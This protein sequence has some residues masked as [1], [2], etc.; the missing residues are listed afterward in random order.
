MK[1]PVF[2]EN[3]YQKFSRD[4]AIDLGTA[5][6]RVYVKNHGI[7]VSEPSVV[8]INQKTGRVVA[9]GT[10]AKQ[11]LG[12]T[13]LHISAERPLVEG[14]ISNFEVAEEMVRYFL[15]KAESILPRMYAR[16]RIL[17]SVPS[18]ITNVERRAV[19]DAVRNA[20]TREVHVIE[21]PVAAA[22][23]ISLPINEPVGSMIV[24]VGGG[25][26]DVAVL[27]LSG[28][29]RSKNLR[30]A[31][32]RLNSDIVNYVKDEFKIFLGDR[33]AEE[34]KIAIGSVQEEDGL[35]E[36]AVRGRD[37]VTGLPREVI[38]TDRDIRE[39]IMPAVGGIVN[40][41]KE[42]LESTPPE[43]VADIMNRGIALAGGGAL[44][45]GLDVLLREELKIPVYLVDDPL[46]AVVRGEGVILESLEHFHDLLLDSED[47]IS[48]Y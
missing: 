33:M 23:G 31:G 19:R 5:N 30:M 26:V 9:V 28:I 2:I 27:S 39:A 36:A 21:S 15:H 7:L 44:I 40:A 37:M 16:P 45:R 3:I 29:V 46:T 38:L 24:L 22:I 4:I 41:I 11:M 10:E 6:T 48:Q 34:V 35:S 17:V 13:P 14:V 8:A 12:R 1:K 25:T 47:E 32:D 18:G 42:V 20:G 43:I